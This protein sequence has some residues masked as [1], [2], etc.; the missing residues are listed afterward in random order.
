MEP[1][2]YD[3]LKDLRSLADGH[4]GGC[5]D[6][7]V[8]DPVD[9]PPTVAIERLA[10]AEGARSYP[11]SVGSVKLRAAA[12]RWMRRRFGVQVSA[13]QTA[14]CVGMKEFVGS[15][16][17][18]L[19]ARTPGCDSVLYPAVS[20]PTYAMGARLAGLRG[21]AVPLDA[22]WRMDLDAVAEDDIRRALCLWVNSPANPTGALEDLV[23]VSAWGRERGVPVFS[24]ECY[25]EFTWPEGASGRSILEHGT[26]GVVAVH[27]LSKRSNFA[28]MRVGCYAGDE[29]LVG[30]LSDA[31]R[32]LGLMVPGPVQA[33]AASA[34]DD[35]EHVGAQRGRYGRRLRML[36]DLLG[37]LGLD[38]DLPEG[39]FYLWV[40]AP[41]GDAWGLTRRLAAEAGLL[42]SP[43]EFY[44]EAGSGHVRV[45]AVAPEERIEMALKRLGAT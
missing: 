2:P 9:S 45:A 27:S 12:V 41:R 4:P 20:Y 16:P 11:P 7:S 19:A 40:K 28:G 10:Q 35:D 29:G 21:V 18:L 42:V 6:L 22:D 39:G 8:G 3:L 26:E 15:L 24:D 14:A 25:I 34:F 32:H 23:E 37:R 30:Y 17:R 38:V 44:G 1:Y 43:G 33:A 5:V 36:A 13:R 31:R